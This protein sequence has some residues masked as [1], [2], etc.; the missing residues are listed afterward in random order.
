MLTRPN[1]PK[2]PRTQVLL[3]GVTVPQT[4]STL[5]RGQLRYMRDAG[6]DVHLAVSPGRGTD[7]VRERESVEVHELPMAREIALK[8]D[9]KAL[10]K[11][12]RLLREVRP[13]VTNVST[14]KA[15]LLGSIASFIHRVPKRVYL[16]RGLRF[17]NEQGVRRAI[18]WAMER[19]TIALS[20]HTLVVSESLRDE[21]VAARLSKRH[22]LRIIGAGSS[23]GVQGE[24]IRRKVVAIDRDVVRAEMGI[25]QGT[26]VVCFVG[27]LAIDKG[28]TD[29]TDALAAPE[30]TGIHLLSLGDTEDPEVVERLR[31]LGDRWHD[32]AWRDDVTPVLAASDVLC[33]PTYREGYPNVVLEASAAGL[34]VVTTNATGA[35]DS[36]IDGKTGFIVDVGDS[37]AL[38]NRL[39][40]LAEDA[41]L[42]LRLGEAA[43]RRAFTDFI[44]ER[45]WAELDRLYRS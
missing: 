5:L 28:I 38:A 3:Y 1:A 2:D 17:E 39:T 18:L 30:A 26:V 16:V 33:L 29:L 22:R 15:A 19:L 21:M 6:W 40:A 32:Q 43:Q 36:V 4:A 27:R 34:P 25:P 37:V 23:N 9:F 20:T 13:A 10:R 24:E 31:T 41:D 8:S 42:R 44:P 12:L 45:I 14:P 35:R 7:L 11:W